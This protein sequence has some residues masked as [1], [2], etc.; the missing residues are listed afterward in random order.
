MPAFIILR[1]I[2]FKNDMASGHETDEEPIN[3]YN[4]KGS[5]KSINE[6]AESFFDSK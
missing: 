6:L 5:D 1:A 2:K 4:V 3:E